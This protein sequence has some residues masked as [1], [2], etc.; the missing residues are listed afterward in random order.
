MANKQLAALLEINKKL[1]EFKLT[2]KQLKVKDKLS[3]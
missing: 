1:N 2:D 3:N